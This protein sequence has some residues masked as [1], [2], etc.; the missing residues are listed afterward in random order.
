VA[1]V[2][3]SSLP[4]SRARTEV[5]VLLQISLRSLQRLLVFLCSDSLSLILLLIYPSAH[6]RKHASR[7]EVHIVVRTKVPF[8]A[9]RGTHMY[10]T[11]VCVHTRARAIHSNDSVSFYTDT[12]SCHFVDHKLTFILLETGRFESQSASRH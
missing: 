10:H 1:L 7:L 9:E 2:P 5:D 4:I 6:Q 3:I 8:I 11:Q 12:A